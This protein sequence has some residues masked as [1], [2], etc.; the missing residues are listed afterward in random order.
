MIPAMNAKSTNTV[1]N[2]A[3]DLGTRR[4]RNH[5]VI[6]KLTVATKNARNTGKKKLCAAFNPA[7]INTTAPHNN[8]AC[9]ARGAINFVSPSISQRFNPLPRPHAT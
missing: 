8:N 3:I 6:G 9:P 2:T 7:T 4:D 5:A 1:S